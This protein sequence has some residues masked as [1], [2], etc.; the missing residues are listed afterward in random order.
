MGASEETIA[1]LKSI[2][3]SL[4]TLVARGGAAAPGGG[5][6]DVADDR[7]L[8]SQYGDEQ[9]KFSPRDYSG[10]SVKGLRM[11]ECPPEA[12]DLLA[13]AYEFF[14]QKNDDNGE[15]TTQGKP[16]STFDRRSARRARGW[17][18]RLR[19]GWKPKTTSSASGGA[20]SA[21]DFG[22]GSDFDSGDVPFQ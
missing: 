12:L 13:T 11:S 14:A 5:G 8:D 21:D 18:K 4:R 22:D 6:S 16:K 19:G 1:L 15:K 2:D 9:I 3:A 10:P 20:E 7:D 17:A